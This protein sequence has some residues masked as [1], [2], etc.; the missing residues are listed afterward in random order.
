MH[1]W[2]DHQWHFWYTIDYSIGQPTWAY[3]TCCV[4][5]SRLASSPVPSQ[6]LSHSREEKSGEGLGSKLCHGPEM[7]DS[8]STNWVHVTYWRSFDP[9]PSPGFSPQLRDQIW[10][11]P[12]DEAS[13][14]HYLYVYTFTYI[15]HS[16][17]LFLWVMA[18]LRNGCPKR[19]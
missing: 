17:G 2:R 12:G 4:C 10:E 7:V 8:V 19:E 18:E 14:R 1:L 6:I 11:R 3:L 9:R 16:I 15:T 13:S 5:T